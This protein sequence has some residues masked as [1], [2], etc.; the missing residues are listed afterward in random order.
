MRSPTPVLPTRAYVRLKLASVRDFLA[1]IV[2]KLRDVPLRSP[3]A[4]AIAVVIERW[5][6][7]A[8]H[9]LSGGKCGC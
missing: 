6:P 3:L 4:H 7:Q 1:S 5:T 2:V 9:F 8:R